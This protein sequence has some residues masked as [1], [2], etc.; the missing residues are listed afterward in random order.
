VWGVKRQSVGCHWAPIGCRLGC[1][2][3]VPTM[4]KRRVLPRRNHI[5][6]K[7]E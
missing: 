4:R 3:G 1:V 2:W 5:Q 6:V 7:M